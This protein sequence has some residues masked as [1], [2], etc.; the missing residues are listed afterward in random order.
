MQV[1]LGRF[2]AC[3]LFENGRVGC[4]GGERGKYD[5]NGQLGI[6]DLV[7]SNE[8][9]KA[10]LFVSSLYNVVQ[11]ASGGK[12]HT[13]VL[14]EDGRVAC[15]GTGSD[16]RLGDGKVYAATG[17]ASFSRSPVWVKDEEGLLVNVVQ[18]GV[19][20]KHSCALTA[21]SKIKCWGKNA[22]GEL[23]ISTATVSSSA[24]AR[25]I[26][27]TLNNVIRI[28]LGINTTCALLSDG[29]V[30]CWGDDLA[31]KLGNG[32]ATSGGHTPS[33]VVQTNGGSGELSDIVQIT[34][35][36]WRSICAVNS[37]GGLRCWGSGAKNQRLDGVATNSQHPV[38]ANTD[39]FG[40]PLKLDTWQSEYRCSRGSCS[41]GDIRLSWGGSTK[42]P[43]NAPAPTIAVAGASSTKLVTLYS[44]RG[45]ATD[46]GSTTASSTSVT[47]NPDL[48]TQEGRYDFYFKTNETNSRCSE[49]FLSYHLDL[50]APDKPTIIVVTADGDVDSPV[51]RVS[52]VVSG[53][54]VDI[55]Q[56]SADCSS[57]K[58]GTATVA[59]SSTSLDI[60][61]DALSS[62]SYQFYAQAYDPAGNSSDC[63]D[64]SEAYIYTPAV[65]FY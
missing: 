23:G 33:Y 58:V 39:A 41:V 42:S 17:S 36:S 10:R 31:G 63:S 61:V 27:S 50:T 12:E 44:G 38:I 60:T 30:K 62:G 64:A 6:P 46:R 28:T 29:K 51:V 1:T 7:N 57:S 35:S 56:G 9:T 2:Y 59:A 14:T 21:D 43:S 3:A 32:T 65:L 18:I 20:E 24:Y 37:M 11:I 26:A 16:G 25:T 4:W 45:C 5:Y 15:W 52:S 19:G 8:I 49:S 34:H 47:I 13:C 22:S 48:G 40:T 54:R 55:F 53:D